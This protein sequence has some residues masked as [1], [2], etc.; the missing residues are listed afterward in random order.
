MYSR[1]ISIG[2]FSDTISAINIKRGMT[3]LL[4]ALY[5]F[6]PI[7]MTLA[8]FRGHSSVRVLTKNFT[9]KVETL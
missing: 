5:L 4:I 1:E 3:V 7:S 9:F 2:I 8:I 6:I